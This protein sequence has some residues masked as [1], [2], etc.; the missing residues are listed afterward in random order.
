MALL[1]TNAQQVKRTGVITKSERPLALP[2]FIK[3][4]KAKKIDLFFV[5]Y[6]LSLLFS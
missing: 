5:C 1:P 4:G 3:V 2:L 6:A